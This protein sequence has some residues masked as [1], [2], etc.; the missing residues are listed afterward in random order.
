MK[1]IVVCLMF[2]FS[3]SPLFAASKEV[4]NEIDALQYQAQQ[5]DEKIKRLQHK[6][7][8]KSPQNAR[9][10][11]AKKSG[12]PTKPADKS[13]HDSYVR[14][15]EFSGHPE[16]FSFYPTALIA[17][18]HVL[19]Y[20][21]GTPVVSSPY[22]GDRPAFDGSDYIVNISSINRDIRLMQ[23][24]RKLYHAYENMGYPIPQMPIISLSGALEPAAL[25]HSDSDRTRTGDFNLGTSELDIAAALN[26]NVEAFMAIAYDSSS[27]PAGGTRVNNSAFNLNM[28]FINIG[29]LDKTPFYFTAGQIYVPFGRYSSAMATSALTL[30][31]ARTK[32]RPFVL[33]YK[34]QGPAGLFAAVYG[35]RGETDLGKSGVGGVNVGYTFAGNDYSGEVGG[36]YIS[37]IN[38]SAGMQNTAVTPF[39]TFGGFSS[40]TNG[41]ELVK[42]IPGA[43]FHANV[44]FDRYSLT[45]EWVGATQS[46]RT[47]DLSYNGHGAKPQAGQ[48]EAG[49]TFMA[50]DKPA[51]VG[52][53]YQYT[54]QALALNL[55]QQ[56][57]NAV[58][59]ISLWKDTIETIGYQHDINYKTTEFGNGAAPEGV[60]NLPTIG[61][62]GSSDTVILQVGVYF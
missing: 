2:V 10:E 61:E 21:A 46:F 3:C 59:N 4:Q 18:N 35:F 42:K 5:L 56:R 40:V 54:R 47:Q 32:S 1:F 11:S 50:F 29:N 20:I 62:G 37:A 39:T 16:S 53:G 26:E 44:S 13:I 23:Q 22:L 31:L 55:P 24:R 12:K 43:D 57:I 30:R 52:I 7:N 36:G 8:N 15:H 6:I 27:P 25:F 17:D 38:E 45:A 41:S 49:M 58:F 14:V 19:T 33:G 48:L 9:E 51:S 34:S 60:V 28:G